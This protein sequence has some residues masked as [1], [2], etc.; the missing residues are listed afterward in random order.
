M[1]SPEE[2]YWTWRNIVSVLFDV[3]VTNAQAVDSFRIKVASYHLGP[4]LVGSVESVGQQFHRSSATVARSGVDHYFVQLY[5]RGGYGG[6]ADGR[7]VRVEPGDISI[8]DLSRTLKTQAESFCNISFVVP[9]PVLA[10]LVKNPD[11]L[12]GIVLSGRS[13]LGSLLANYMNT[14]HDTAGALSAAEGEAIAHPTASLIAGCFGPSADSEEVVV[15]G[16]RSAHLLAIKRY[17][18]ENLADPG[19]TVDH[20]SRVFHLSRATLA[21]MFEPLGGLA[22][23]IREL[24]MLRCF[25]DITSPGHSH[26]S[27]SDLAY[28]WGFSNEAAFSRAFRQ[29]FDMAPREARSA[30]AFA[31]HTIRERLARDQDTTAPIL[32]QWIRHLKV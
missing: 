15:Q 10:P 17:I 20:I 7:S 25:A 28:A 2:A 22:G 6:E 30:A 24:R 8:L 31:R 9:R 11:G 26:R 16:L 13:A 32:A 5:S 27:I 23:Y 18:N 4:L 19:L 14:V 1:S 21:R 12:H 29:A 3:S